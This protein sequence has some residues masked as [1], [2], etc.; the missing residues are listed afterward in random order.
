MNAP[1]APPS[2]KSA[3]ARTFA[4]DVVGIIPAPRILGERESEEKEEANAMDY[5]ATGS[6]DL[7]ITSMPTDRG[8]E[9]N[10]KLWRDAEIVL[11]GLAGM[12]EDKTGDC[13]GVEYEGAYCALVDAYNRCIEERR[14]CED[15]LKLHEKWE[16]RPVGGVAE[17]S[18]R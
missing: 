18:E 15:L 10:L 13:A 11:D 7:W 9:G 4:M 6:E 17:P 14:R 5:K 8:P 2:A 12:Y 1:R 16:G 3:S